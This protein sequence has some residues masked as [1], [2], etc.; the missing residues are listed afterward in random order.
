VRLPNGAPAALVCGHGDLRQLLTDDRLGRAGA[1]AHGMTARSTESLALN[2]ADP[3]D[4][5]RRRRT[6]AAAFTSRRAEAERPRIR[7]TARDL[8]AGMVAQGQQADLIADFSL[9]LSVAVI[10]RIMGVPATD[11]PRFGPLVGV[12]MSTHGHSAQ[13][14]RTAHTQM[15]DYFSG[16]YDAELLVSGGSETVLGDLVVAAERDGILSR[17]EAIHMAYGLLMAGYETTSNQ[18]AICVALLLAD[19]SRWDRLRGDPGALRPAIEEMLRWTSLLATGGVPH[20]ALE[21]M[22][23]SGHEVPAGQVLVPV[24]SAANRD[25]RAFADP[26]RLRL[27]RGGSTHLAFG[28]GRHLCLGAP[29]A[30]VELEEALRALLGALPALELAVSESGLRWRQGTFIRGLT[31]LPVRW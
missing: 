8:V 2:S 23:L 4:H 3:P 7:R 17:D 15:F 12:M 6:V 31:E 27:D 16:L 9:P 30:R 29:L 14:V 20:I 18:I 11:L 25:P 10:C 19:R 21:D 13:A 5:T 1:A 24:F 26:N 22:V 28:H